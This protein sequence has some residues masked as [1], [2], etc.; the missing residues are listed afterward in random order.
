MALPEAISW[1][2]RLQFISGLTFD[3][4]GGSLL[5]TIR[6]ASAP[7]GEASAS[8][9]WRFGVHGAATQI[10]R[11]P[12]SDAAAKPSP[13]DD[14]IAFISDR[15]MPGKM[16]LLLLRAEISEAQ[17][18]GDVP[19]C[20][21]DFAWAADGLT[22]VVLSA[23]R[24]LN[25]GATSGATR[26]WWGEPQDPE[27]TTPGPALRRL[28]RITI[29]TGETEEVGPRDLTVWEF[30]LVPQGAVAVVSADASERGWHHPK[31]VR[32]DFQGRRTTMLHETD[33][34][35]Q[36][37]AADPTGSRVAFLQ[38]WSSDRGL[39]AGEIQVL[40][41]A[42]HA[43]STLAADQHSNVTALRW[44][45]AGS[46]WF[47]GWQG[48]GTVYGIVTTAGE[49]TWQA[50]ENATIGESAFV[51][52][53]AVSPDGKM[54]AAVRETI[55]NPQEIFHKADRSADWNK[56]SDIN[57]AVASGFPDYPEVRHLTWKARDGLTLESFVYVPSSLGPGPHPMIVDIH[58]GPCMSTK[59]GF[60]PCGALGFAAAGYVVFVPNYRGNV[61][62]GQA[63]ARMNLGD[64]AGAEFD[65]IMAGVDKCIDIGLA[66]PERLGVT[67][68]SYGGYLSAWAVSATNRFKAAVPAFSICNQISSH[69]GCEHDFHEFINGGSLRH[70]ASRRIAIERSPLHR[71][72]KPATPTL[73]I[74]GQE[75]RCTP[76]G[77][78]QEFYSALRERGVVAELVVYPREGHGLREREH[79]FDSWQRRL[80]WFD[81]YLR[82]AQTR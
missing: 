76:L 29:A 51:A 16:E 74:Q 42:T 60:D 30:C 9:I 53:M 23:D 73:L 5:A 56:L 4:T 54:F 58:G 65:D 32:I 68:A 48:L 63:F 14:S 20:V 61:G 34:Q 19:G 37:L 15:R 22:I 2:D 82:L 59:Y 36:G 39:V 12:N 81:R 8:R 62:W 35:V 6:P 11:G 26:L 18:I 44:L 55:G 33:W 47:T 72:E 66:D 17:P 31:L 40:D 13:A 71:L 10:T 79:R 24:G 45:D 69:Y 1:L 77:Q 64:P 70:E 41:L 80:S 78:A 67:G 43:L 7:K 75:D 3:R 25:G 27:V 21:E 50:S 28:F 38:G 46:L 49:V 52:Q 57:G